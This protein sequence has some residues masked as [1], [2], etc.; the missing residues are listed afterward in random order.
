MVGQIGTLS[1]V[2]TKENGDLV[3]RVIT[4]R[5]S[6]PGIATVD[7]SGAVRAVATG[8]ATITAS[9]GEA[10]ASASLQV[11]PAPVAN[12]SRAAEWTTYQG[13][14]QHTS[15][16][17]ATLDP[18]AFTLRWAKTFAASSE[19]VQA[20]TGGSR[21]FVVSEQPPQHV[22]ALN[23]SDG[24]T[25]WTYNFGNV[26]IAN[27]AAYDNGSVY[28]TT[29]G[30]SDTY[31][32]A[33]R[34]TDGSLRFK[35]PFKSQWDAWFAPVVAGAAIVTGGG[36]YGGMYGFDRSTGQQLFFVG[37]TQY[38]GRWSPA[39]ANGMVYTADK[40]L[41]VTEPATGQTT[42]VVSDELLR[43]LTVPIISA[44]NSLI[45]VNDSRLF[46]IDINAKTKAWEQPVDATS[47]P[48]VGNG[49]IYLRNG[50][51]L[52]A[53]RESDG[54]VLWSVALPSS[55]SVGSNMILTNNL[56]LATLY[57]P[58]RD[59]PAMTIAIDLASHLIVWEYPESGS[60]ALSGQGVLYITHDNRV[61]AISM[62]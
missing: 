17:D 62:K 41:N 29:S 2:V 57:P 20:T 46:R 51:K 10:S 3:S 37:G 52:E 18:R 24:S 13:N 33:L 61:T 28:V 47:L 8:T 4:W 22:L 35:T 16:V 42:K 55:Y 12:W 45:S 56:L 6:A 53:R 44:D 19:Y 27:Q 9:V 36:E 38:L 54:T 7:A 23:T 50:T 14:A 15:Y 1:A 48:V 32:Y 59:D 49:V 58:R 26:F 39:A 25:A 60:L 5:S 21:V 43:F 11:L 31:M 40:G 30:Q 34:E